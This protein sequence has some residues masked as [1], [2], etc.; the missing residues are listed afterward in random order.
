MHLTHLWGAVGSHRAAPRDHPNL[1]QYLSQGYWLKIEPYTCFDI[2][3]YP[4]QTHMNIRKTCSIQ[5]YPSQ[6]SNPGYSC[7]EGTVLTTELPCH[8][9]LLAV[10]SIHKTRASSH[11][12]HT[13]MLF[14]NNF[15]SCQDVLPQLERVNVVISGWKSQEM[16]AVGETSQQYEFD[17]VTFL[18]YWTHTELLFD[19]SINILHFIW[20][21]C[22]CCCSPWT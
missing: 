16:F 22:I 2:G 14:G 15:I 11:I 19:W 8:M 21:K 12:E 4:E 1:S 18:S 10:C 17:I 7:Y 13:G 9:V 5:P 20:E 6:E 3:E